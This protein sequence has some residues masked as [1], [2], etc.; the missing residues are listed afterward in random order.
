MKKIFFVFLTFILVCAPFCFSSPVAH[1]QEP[2]TEKIDFDKLD[3][4][5]LGGNKNILESSTKGEDLS[6]PGKIV[7][8]ALVYAFPI[9]GII[10]FVMILWGGLEM[11]G[12]AAET[13]S[14]EAGKQRIT[15]AVIGFLIL[16][17]AYWITQVIQIVFGV[18][19]L[20]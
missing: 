7:S 19:I 20:G 17:T 10:L 12:G 14:L 6:T 5:K 16:F 8:R 3:P 13:K 18:R 4:L 9:A 1:A 11:L 2:P 15:A